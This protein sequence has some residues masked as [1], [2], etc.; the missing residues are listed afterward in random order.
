LTF[1]LAGR[2]DTEPTWSV[3]RL[4]DEIR[5]F[6]SEAFSGLWVAGEVQR[7]RRSQRGHVY[8]ELVEK[9][10]GDGVKAKL[11]AVVWRSDAQRVDSILAASDQVLAEGM[12]IR[13]RGGID[14][15]G[16]AGRLQLIVRE[17]DPVFTLG[18]LERRRREILAELAAA[19]LLEVNKAL[20]LPDLPLNLAL[21]TSEGSA[22]CHDFLATLAE[23]GYGFRV[24]LFH[25]AVQGKGAEGEIAAALA[26]AGRL[27]SRGGADLIALVRG[28]G[29]RTDLA[30]FDSRE[31]ALAVARSPLPVLTGLGHEI[32]EAIA[33]KVAH[34]ALKTPT[35]VA[36]FLVAKV[37]EAEWSLREVAAELRRLA[38]ETLSRG[39]EAL[40]SAEQ[41]ITLARSRLLLA[42]A[43]LDEVR[44]TLVRAARV[45]LAVAEIS[46]KAL[47]AGFGRE[48]PRLLLARS[49]EPREHAR[50]L[51]AAG[52][53]H[54]KAAR[55]TVTG[56]E[57]LCR[58][59]A[60]ERTLER[61]FSITRGAAGQ[62]VRAPEAVAAGDLLTTETAGGRLVSRVEEA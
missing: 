35:K 10:D 38:P 22:A 29:S 45:R 61:G 23:S 54:L 14:F 58:D 57:R 31:V 18:L 43:R 5:L 27:G 36:E 25:T 28:G 30:V 16:P 4:C 13:C 49:R 9:D 59:L 3:S 20:E 24:S 2:T 48:A 34:T 52:T 46:R 60:P 40:A 37:M 6:L 11:D 39:R 41:R 51:V 21:V 15:Y 17:V 62:L 33:D 12:E 1:P 44:R 32:D 8:F 7:L 47:A 56:L 55:A 19:G 50:A 42:A 26:A 53:G